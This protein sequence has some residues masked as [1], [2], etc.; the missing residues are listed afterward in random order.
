MFQR[1]RL[2]DL[3]P[4]EFTGSISPSYGPLQGRT[5]NHGGVMDVQAVNQMDSCS[6][7]SEKTCEGK[8]PEGLGP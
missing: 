7:V 3:L 2:G 6:T 1:K 4:P 8:E 5:M